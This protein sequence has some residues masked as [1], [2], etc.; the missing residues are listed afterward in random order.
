ME[1][2]TE[3]SV[4]GGTTGGSSFACEG[5][6]RTPCCVTARPSADR[7]RHSV[8]LREQRPAAVVRFLENPANPD[9][10]QPLES[11]G[12]TQFS[13]CKNTTSPAP[14]G[15]KLCLEVPAVQRSWGPYYRRARRAIRSAVRLE[16]PYSLSYQLST[17]SRFPPM[18]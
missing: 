18:T 11:H 3:D 1:M 5:R 15:R 9:L 7:S 17:V 8:H 12:L 10:T 2:K 6:R 16:Y 4:R 13:P 14:G